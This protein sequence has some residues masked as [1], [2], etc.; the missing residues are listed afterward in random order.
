LL[1]HTKAEV[2]V[3]SARGLANFETMRKSAEENIYERSK[4]YAKHWIVLR[5]ILELLTL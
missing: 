4:G 3:A 2:L 5:F 1:R